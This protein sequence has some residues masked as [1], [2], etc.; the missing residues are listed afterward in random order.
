MRFGVTHSGHREQ[1]AAD[2]DGDKGA[3]EDQPVLSE[4]L[5][6]CGSPVHAGEHRPDDHRLHH[7]PPRIK[8]VRTPGRDDPESPHGQ[9]QDQRLERWSMSLDLADCCQDEIVRPFV[10]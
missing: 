6:E 4:R 1:F 5:G 10:V 7:R 8:Q 2:L 3:R 9:Q